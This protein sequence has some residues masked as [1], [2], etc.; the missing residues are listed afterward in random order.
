MLCVEVDGNGC[1]KLHKRTTTD[2]EVVRQIPTYRAIFTSTAT[3]II[4]KRNTKFQV[5]L[6][7]YANIVSMLYIKIY[8]HT[9]SYK[10]NL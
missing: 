4:R 10:L 8:R 2:K 5:E 9:S 1:E 7:E 3:C 6:Y